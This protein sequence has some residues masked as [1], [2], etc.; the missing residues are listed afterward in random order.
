MQSTSRNNPHLSQ[1]KPKTRWLRNTSSN[2]PTVG[3]RSGID[4]IPSS[5][6]RL[7]A[8]S[9]VRR[10]HRRT[11]WVRNTPQRLPLYWLLARA[12][13]HSLGSVVFQIVPLMLYPLTLLPAGRKKTPDAVQRKGLHPDLFSDYCR[14]PLPVPNP[15]I[16]SHIS[17]C[18]PSPALVQLQQP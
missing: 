1:T 6:R 14:F 5:P 17:I 4:E 2:M 9:P 10:S 12:T 3:C 16:K 7:N 15:V 8:A 13:V 18:Y 11:L